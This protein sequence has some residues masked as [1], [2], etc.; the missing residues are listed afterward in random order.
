MLKYI[1]TCLKGYLYIAITIYKG[2]FNFLHLLNSAYNLNLYIKD[3][4]SVSFIYRFD[5]ILNNIKEY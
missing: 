1:Q 2:Q 5:C 3:N 4:S